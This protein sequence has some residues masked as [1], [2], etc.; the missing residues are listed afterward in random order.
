M[1]VEDIKS[2]SVEEKFCKPLDKEYADLP[3]LYNQFEVF[4]SLLTMSDEDVD[5]IY[6]KAPG[7]IMIIKSRLNR[8]SYDLD[9]K[10]QVMLSFIVETPGDA[11]MYVYYLAYKAKQKNKDIITFDD[12]VDIFPMGYFRK[13]QLDKAWDSQK[14]GGANLLDYSEASESLNQNKD[15]K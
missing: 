3:L 2:N 8:L 1:V 11:V 9:K 14:I 6:E 13:Q 7:L 4:M 15:D 5:E 12:F 10:T